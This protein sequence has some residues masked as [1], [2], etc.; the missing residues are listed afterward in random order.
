MRS[1]PHGRLLLLTVRSLKPNGHSRRVYSWRKGCCSDDGRLLLGIELSS[2][3][4][5]LVA[6]N[7]RSCI[8]STVPQQLVILVLLRPW[9]WIRER[10]YWVQCSKDAKNYCRK[11]DLCTFRQGPARKI[12]APLSRYNVGAPMERLAIDVLGPLL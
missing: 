12:R 3:W 4:C 2:S 11:C 9:I 6:C 10:F 7:C 5:Y 1:V 8:N